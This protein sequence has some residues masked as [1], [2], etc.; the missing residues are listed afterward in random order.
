[1][2]NKIIK[3][4]NYNITTPCH[5]FNSLNDEKDGN[6]LIKNAKLRRFY[7]TGTKKGIIST[8]RALIASGLNISDPKIKFGLYT[9]QYGYLHPLPSELLPEH[10]QAKAHHSKHIYQTIWECERVNPFLITLSLSNNL[11]GI[12]S[13]ELNLQCDCAA[14]LRG[15]LGLLSAFSEA[16]LC[17]NNHL[18]DYALVV[19]SGIGSITQDIQSEFSGGSIEFGATFILTRVENQA[20]QGNSHLID[21]P[22]LY[23]NYSER[24]YAAET[25]FFIKDIADRIKPHRQ[26]ETV[27]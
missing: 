16:E 3:L 11:L 4:I 24:N 5:L 12:L 21:I 13:Q 6:E 10:E 15:N 23:Q 1:M 8:R 2:E 19:A 7:S 14:F 20:P 9:T 17:L 25:L 26:V 18:I 27:N 22:Y